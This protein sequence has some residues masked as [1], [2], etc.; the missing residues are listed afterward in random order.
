MC[1]ER[2]NVSTYF[3]TLLPTSQINNKHQHALKCGS[4][5]ILTQIAVKFATLHSIECNLGEVGFRLKFKPRTEQMVQVLG[6]E[7]SYPGLSKED[8]LYTA[9]F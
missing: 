9:L 6:R 2:K 8:T 3:T 5:V 4:C 7:K 1:Y